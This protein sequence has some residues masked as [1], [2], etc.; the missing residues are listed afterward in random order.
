MKNFE[1]YIEELKRTGDQCAFIKKHLHLEKDCWNM[2]CLECEK[3]FF[4]WLDSEYKPQIDWSRVPIDT[5]V[6]FN[7]NGLEYKGHFA[8][9]GGFDLVNVYDRGTTSWSGNSIVCTKVN[10]LRLA[11]EEDIEKYSI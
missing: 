2:H 3:R 9:Y 7:K 6:F 10:Y 5:P 11:R 1:K 4:E 8:G